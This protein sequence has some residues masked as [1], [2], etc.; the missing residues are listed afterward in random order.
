M[1]LVTAILV[2][3]C[4]GLI[5]CI[6][7]AVLFERALRGTGKVSAASGSV[8]I[9]ASALFLSAAL[10]VVWRAA[11]EWLLT[12]GCSLAASFLLFWGV[13]ALRACKVVNRDQQAL[14]EGDE[15]R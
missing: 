4:V 9:I 8:S 2:G 11:E 10:L 6:P 1:N 15:T 13:E 5:G 12:F 7:S 3:A 14:R